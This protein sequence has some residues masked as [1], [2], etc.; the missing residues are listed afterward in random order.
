MR[1]PCDS[2]PKGQRLQFVDGAA[3]V[4][5]R[6]LMGKNGVRISDVMSE[7]RTK[8]QS[9]RSDDHAQS[10]RERGSLRAAAQSRRFAPPPL[11]SGPPGDRVRPCGS[12]ASAGR[13]RRPSATSS[14]RVRSASCRR[15]TLARP[16][17]LRSSC[18]RPSTARR[19]LDA[20]DR[21]AAC[22]VSSPRG[23]RAAPGSGSPC[24]GATT[25]AWHLPTVRGDGYGRTRRPPCAPS[26][27]R[28]RRRR[29]EPRA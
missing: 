27:S 14:S 15:A 20:H 10:R 23:G 21:L 19:Y 8:T 5:C 2:L 16:S 17:A 18:T 28:R 9:R 4:V 7:L 24:S 13:L 11:R 3:L 1:L 25:P 26:G 29:D 12:E 22:G 6:A